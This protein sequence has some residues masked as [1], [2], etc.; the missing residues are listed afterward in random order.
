VGVH[1]QDY[2]MIF[3]FKCTYCFENHQTRE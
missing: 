2:G 1:T 3:F